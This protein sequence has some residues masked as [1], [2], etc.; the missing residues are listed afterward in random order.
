MALDPTHADRFPDKCSPCHALELHEASKFPESFV[1]PS[2]VAKCMQSIPL[3]ITSAND[4]IDGTL[5][6]L[7]IYSYQY[8]A[9][10]DFNTQMPEQVNLEGELN[11]IRQ[12]FGQFTTLPELSRRVSGLFSGLYDGHTGMQIDCISRIGFDAFLPLANIAPTPDSPPEIVVHP[13]YDQFLVD[14]KINHT[15]QFSLQKSLA[16]SKVL[17]IDGKDARQYM[18]DL[19]TNPDIFYGNIDPETRY[20]QLFVNLRGHP[21]P[22]LGYGVALTSLTRSNV[23]GDLLKV[24]IGFAN[25][26]ETEVF[27]PWLGSVDTDYHKLKGQIP[28]DRY[29][30]EYVCHQKNVSEL[31]D[32]KEASTRTTD[33]SSKRRSD[34]LSQAT[35]TLERRRRTPLYDPEYETV[36]S[37]PLLLPDAYVSRHS[38]NLTNGTILPSSATVRPDSAG[39]LDKIAQVDSGFEI[40]HFKNTTVA[41]I[42]YT[43]FADDNGEKDDRTEMSV[44]YASRYRREMRR[45]LIELKNRGVKHLLIEVSGNNGGRTELGSLA[46]LYLFPDQ[47]PG[48]GTVFRSNR[49]MYNYLNGTNYEQA[50]CGIDGIPYKNMTSLLAEKNSTMNVNGVDASYTRLTVDNLKDEESWPIIGSAVFPSKPLFAPKNMLIVTNGKCASTC[51]QVVMYF[52]DVHKIKSVGFG[53]S[54]NKASLLQTVGGVR[55]AQVVEMLDPMDRTNNV[56]NFSMRVTQMTVNFRSAIHYDKRVPTEYVTRNVDYSYSHTLETFNSFE[57]T[58]KSVADRHFAKGMKTPPTPSTEKIVWRPLEEYPPGWFDRLQALEISMNDRKETS[59][60]AVLNSAD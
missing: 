35:G 6:M 38:A 43:N 22:R 28:F 20:N 57:N 5:S 10:D 15:E 40:Y 46:M 51:A 55:G 33:F 29:Y 49:D 17:Q 24:K 52:Q 54:P 36:K 1:K 16:G 3:N 58:W 56:Y 32:R 37:A 27:I 39:S 25:G 19:T 60:P 21:T 30:S 41:V 13:D 18:V 11:K 26:T 34:L 2:E 7:D 48:F 47:Y 42:Y 8:Y 53:G 14:R 44:T 12:G 45:G 31:V 23:S 9:L 4:L 59:Y 50:F